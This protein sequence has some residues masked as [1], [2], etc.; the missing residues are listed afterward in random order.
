MTFRPPSLR[1]ISAFEAAART[2]SFAKAAVELSLT[3]SAVSHA[4]R[5]LEQRLNQTLF[6]RQGRNVALTVAGQT[7]AGRVR[8][9]MA[10]LSDAFDL[11]HE[12]ATDRLVVSA[13]PSMAAKILL[14]RLGSLKA[15]FPGLRLQLRVTETLEDFSD[16]QVDVALRFGPG[17]WSGL[18]SLVLA[19]EALTPM[20]SPT[21]RD[22]DIPQTVEALRECDLIRQME[23][24]W[25]KWLD[26]LGLDEASFPS[27]LQ[28]SDTAMGLDVAA[29]G[30]GVVLG[31]VRM[32]QEDLR[33]RRLV[34]LFDNEVRAQY[35]YACVWGERNVREGLI[36]RFGAWLADEL[37]SDDDAGGA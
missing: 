28:V 24:S 6:E 33:Q 8:L 25:R 21:Y 1:A 23:S 37:R 15:A 36:E 19:E 3:P 29:R 10:L 22:G 16:G 14:P 18:R 32:A 30:H 9:G 11:G 17:K 26:P 12:Q 27:W 31:R 35:V 7:F 34:R 5:G 20:C 4:I 2:G 13:L